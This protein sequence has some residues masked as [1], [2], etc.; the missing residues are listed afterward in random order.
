[1]GEWM[2]YTSH[3]N[4]EDAV[5]DSKYKKMIISYIKKRIQEGDEKEL[6]AITKKSL[7]EKEPSTQAILT[8]SGHYLS[9]KCGSEAVL[10]IGSG[11]DWLENPEF[12]GVIS[13]MPHGC[14]PGGI[15]AAMADKFSSIYQKPW[16][17]LT[18]DGFLETNNSIRINEF[19]ELVKFCRKNQP[20]RETGR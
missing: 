12:A 5:K 8:K 13:V 19:A 11:I 1:M 16:I 15:V 2:K 7:K 10:S 18:Y 17:N 6:P 9:S 4:L 3:R 14:M 20:D